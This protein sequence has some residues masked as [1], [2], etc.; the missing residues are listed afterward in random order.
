MAK[1]TVDD[2][3]AVK[4]RDRLLRVV[5]DHYDDVI[6]KFERR[7][8]IGHGTVRAWFHRNKPTPPGVP[9]LL[10]FGRD[11]KIRLSLDGLLLGV[12]PLYRPR[13]T[14]VLS[15]RPREVRRMAETIVDQRYAIRGLERRL[16]RTEKKLQSLSPSA[17]KPRQR[18]G[19]AKTTHKRRST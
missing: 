15:V 19:I 4:I 11:V 16:A 7:W 3:D 13:L 9:Y 14:S 10:R 12:G 17:R 1:Q 8:R 18:G 5:K 6:A 2:A